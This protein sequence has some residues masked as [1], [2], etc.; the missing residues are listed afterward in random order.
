MFSNY[1]PLLKASIMPDATMKM[2][3]MKTIIGALPGSNREVLNMLLAMAVHIHH[4]EEVNRMTPHN[5][6]VVLGP[7]ILRAQKET[8]ES[9]MRDSMQVVKVVEDMIENY[10]ELFG[11]KTIEIQRP[12]SLNPQ[13]AEFLRK[14]AASLFPSSVDKSIDE[15][16]AEVLQ[17]KS[18]LVEL[19]SR[20]QDEGRE[21]EIL[22]AYQA[23][24]NAKVAEETD[25]SAALRVEVQSLLEQNEKSNKAHA[26]ALEATQA[27]HEQKN[28]GVGKST[29]GQNSVGC[30]VRG[31]Y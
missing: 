30:I 14:R 13:E 3:V 9:M 27:D 8:L 23:S 6:A 21:K 18:Q 1:E 24:L 17:L 10:G 19:E 5:I 15:W 11:N 25:N 7:T 28:F 16:R 31:F 26:E 12:V 20:L 29:F 4:K 2:K 22:L